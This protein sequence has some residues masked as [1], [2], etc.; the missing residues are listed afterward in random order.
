VR[1]ESEVAVHPTNKKYRDWYVCKELKRLREEKAAKCNLA[2]HKWDVFRK[3]KRTE[4]ELDM[5]RAELM[6]EIDY[7]G[8]CSAVLAKRD[9]RETMLAKLAPSVV[10]APISYAWNVVKT[11]WTSTYGSQGYGMHSYTRAALLPLEKKLQELGF[12]TH[13]RFELWHKAS[14]RWS[15]GDGGVYRLWANATDWQADAANRL[16]DLSF[17]SMAVG[18]TT[19]LAVLCPGLPPDM[20]DKHFDQRL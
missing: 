15:C 20:L 11:S 7:D 16:I 6:Q 8:L 3:G 19:N 13:V 12:K 1:K 9:E 4:G 14:G 17:Y 10:F 5:K 2:Q 18:R